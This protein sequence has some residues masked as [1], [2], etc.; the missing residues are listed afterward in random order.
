[1][2]SASPV[3]ANSWVLRCNVSAR[4]KPSMPRRLAMLISQAPGLAGTPWSG[5]CSRAATSASC[6]RSS[7]RSRSRVIRVSAPTS[8]ADSV[9]QIVEIVSA[10]V[11]GDTATA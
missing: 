11:V 10:V 1:M 7:A 5:H 2:A 4:R 3:R 6:A 9:R 8:R